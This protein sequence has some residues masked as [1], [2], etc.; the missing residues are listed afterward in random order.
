MVIPLTNMK[1]MTWDEYMS[2]TDVFQD[3][4]IVGEVQGR[5]IAVINLAGQVL[6]VVE[7][8]PGLISQWDITG[9]AN[10]IQ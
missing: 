10:E 1:H 4:L 9:G 6:L 8:E 7:H 2:K 3:M 5:H